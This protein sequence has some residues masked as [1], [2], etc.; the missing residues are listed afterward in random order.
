MNVKEFLKKVKGRLLVAYILI[1]LAAGII[2]IFGSPIEHIRRFFSQYRIISI[3]Y[4]LAIIILSVFY[5]RNLEESQIKEIEKQTFYFLGP[6]PSFVIGVFTN[7]SFFYVGLLVINHVFNG[8]FSTGLASTENIIIGIV[9]GSLIY[10]CLSHAIKMG[11]DC[12][13]AS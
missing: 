3:I 12:F 4:G 10:Q 8:T 9:M 2:V 7:I 6:F 13:I 5:Y 11:R 1:F